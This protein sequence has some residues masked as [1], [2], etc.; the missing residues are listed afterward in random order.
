M[1]AVRVYMYKCDPSWG[2]LCK[3]EQVEMFT[4]VIWSLLGRKLETLFCSFIKW[5]GLSATVGE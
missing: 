4:S 5:K 1:K 3:L 2:W